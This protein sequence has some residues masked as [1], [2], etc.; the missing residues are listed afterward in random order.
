[1]NA[2]KDKLINYIRSN[3]NVEL[4]DIAY[5]LQT[6]KE[7]FEYRNSVVGCTFEEITGK[8]TKL[9]S[10]FKLTKQSLSSSPEIVFMFSGQG[11]QYPNMCRALYNSEICFKNN[12]DRCCKVLSEEMGI[13]FKTVLFPKVENS[14]AKNLL[15]QTKYTQPALFT[16]CY[17]LAKQ[18][19]E[20]GIKAV[21]LIGHSIG[22]YTAAV[23]SGV[24]T[25]EDGLKIVAK[26]G[27]LMQQMTRGS[28]LSINASESVIREFLPD[29]IEFSVFNTPEY[30]VVSGEHTVITDFSDFLTSRNIISTLLHTSHAFHSRMMDEMIKPF[31]VFLQNI[32]MNSPTIPFIS[33]ITGEYISEKQAR[34]AHY[35]S[36]QVRKAVQFSR[37]LLNIGK[38]YPNAVYVELGAGNILASFAKQH[39]IINKNGKKQQ[40]KAVYS[41]MPAKEFELFRGNDLQT[42]EALGKLWNYG[43]DI[44]WD[45]IH[46]NKTEKLQPVSYLL[47]TYQFDR[48]RC[49]IEKPEENRKIVFASSENHCLYQSARQQ[50]KLEKKTKIEK[51]VLTE[52]D[53]T[54]IEKKIASIFNEVLGIEE[55]SK[56]DD[57]FELGGSSLL[58]IQVSSKCRKAG[59]D[60]SIKDIF[61]QRTISNLAGNLPIISDNKL[62]AEEETL[63]GEFDLLPIQKYFFERHLLAGNT[64]SQSFLIRTPELNLTKLKEA[65]KNLIS[66]HDNLRLTFQNGKQ[67]YSKNIAIPELKILDRK[68]VSDEFFSKILV[69]WQSSFNIEE[70][71]LWSVGYIYGYNDNSARIF[72]AAHHL[73]ID[74]VS[75]YIIIE[76]I[77]KL[78]NGEEL[79]NETHRYRQWVAAVKKYPVNNKLELNYW[80][81]IIKNQTDYAGQTSEKTIFTEISFDK[82]FTS[83][84][85][86]HASKAYHTE[87][88]DLL[89]TALTYSLK[90]RTGEKVAYITL[91][92]NARDQIN[93]S[94]DMSRT[95]GCFTKAYPVR[96]ELKSDISNSIKCIK[97][98]LR[99]IPKNGIGYGAI[100][101][102]EN[103]NPLKGHILPL[104]YFNYLGELDSTIDNWQLLLEKPNDDFF[105]FNENAININ[106]LVFEGELKFYITSKL[107]MN[108]TDRFSNCLRKHFNEIIRHCVSRKKIEYTISDFEIKREYEEIVIQNE[109]INT[110]CLIML[111]PAS[112]GAE[113]Y[114]RT[115]CKY[116]R[117]DIR[118]ILINNYKLYSQSSILPQSIEQTAELYIKFILDKNII[119]DQAYIVGWSWGGTLSYEILYQLQKKGFNINKAFLIDPVFYNELLKTSDDLSSL[120]CDIMH[121]QYFPN[122]IDSTNTDIF[123]LKC[124]N[125]IYEDNVSQEQNDYCQFINAV[126]ENK[127]CGLKFLVNKYNLIKLQCH[128]DQVL[129]K[130]YVENIADI[131]NKNIGVL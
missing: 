42:Y 108:E 63:V 124:M 122:K 54:D 3:P 129:D 111:H 40:L 36:T 105:P 120:S 16:I 112:S 15:K 94:L 52:K 84:L 128:H 97:E 92:N 96:L 79:S 23:L 29:D 31:E 7:L 59:F 99:N 73:I 130:P 110:P 60:I 14:E 67:K 90:D 1:M 109:R 72:I 107:S 37:G 38:K 49:W 21:S 4:C 55:I 25:L 131:I 30:C 22:E 11:A 45:L 114:M 69:E 18:F 127:S 116:L 19:E 61:S 20:W 41:V 58:S 76:D 123:L 89:L 75:L 33:N 2:Y 5:A 43:Y 6:K 44:N 83:K 39:Y 86:K 47:P 85:I 106:C 80:K 32:K 88:T 101:C 35:W 48:I 91:C 81:E 78:Y 104:V 26:R 70:G 102:Y 82:N 113:A 9:S 68:T 77:K 125:K 126:V 62:T 34:S 93:D 51:Q 118:L 98:Y 74:L 53:G 95:I 12:I 71:P 100:K 65:I 117:S 13:D 56:N 64:C 57:F 46:Q 115:L 121:K 28:M 24:F 27:H 17:S 50:S 87:I 10:P 103:S 119:L 8:L 66:Y